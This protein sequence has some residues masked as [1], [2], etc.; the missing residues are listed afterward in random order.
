MGLRFDAG[1]A[2]LAVACIGA[3]PR[4][5]G[6]AALAALTAAARAYDAQSSG[7]IVDRIVQR[8]HAKAAFITI[9]RTQDFVEM[10]HDGRITA[11]SRVLVNDHSKNVS[12]KALE[13]QP[14]PG[15]SDGGVG[16]QHHFVFSARYL[17]EYRL[18]PQSCPKCAASQATVAF[19]SDMHDAA[20]GQGVVTVDVADD[21]VVS[22]TYRP[23]VLPDRRMDS[24]VATVTFGWMGGAW[25][26]VQ[27]HLAFTAHQ[28]FIYASGT[29]DVECTEFHRYRTLEPA[30]AAYAGMAS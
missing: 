17:H 22:M 6:S 24:G 21:R 14:A 28:F 10:R 12:S 15:S 18:T 13:Q 26:P 1:A 7:Y 20:H 30:Q 8:I 5:N 2:V 27:Y 16:M 19:D 11:S 4:P 23:Y 9:N 3:A 25:V 29:A